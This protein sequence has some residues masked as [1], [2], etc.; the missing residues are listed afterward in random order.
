MTNNQVCVTAGGSD[1]QASSIGT[2]IPDYQ[3]TGVSTPF[4]A[5]LDAALLVG[6]N[7]MSTYLHIV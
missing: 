2:S 3:Y 1:D 4:S 6:W 5:T 7:I